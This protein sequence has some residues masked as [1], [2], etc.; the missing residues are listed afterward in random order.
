MH[1][2]SRSGLPS[3][4]VGASAIMQILS[5]GR[6]LQIPSGSAYSKICGCH[7]HV[8]FQLLNGFTLCLPATVSN[9]STTS[10][11]SIPYYRHKFPKSS[12]PPTCPALHISRWYP[13]GTD[14][15]S[16]PNI[17]TGLSVLHTRS[18][19]VATA[20]RSRSRHL[21]R[22]WFYDGP[23]FPPKPWH[24]RE[25]IRAMREQRKLES[26]A[27]ESHQPLKF[28][29]EVGKISGPRLRSLCTIDGL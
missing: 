3:Y 7:G 17:P 18:T 23:P 1:K 11:T 22:R 8:W 2:S 4:R 6:S 24:A 26:C 12:P 21:A 14:S 27:S 25:M 19:S 13:R 15:A 5:F 29:N 28:W 9:F 10:L 16:S 20:H